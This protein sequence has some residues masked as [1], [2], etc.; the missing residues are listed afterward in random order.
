MQAGDSFFLDGVAERHLWVI[1]SDPTVNPERVLFVSMTS[2][3]VTKEDVCL[4]DAGDH[5][6]V[7][8]KTCIDY[9]HAREATLT[10]LVRL[11]DS[12]RLRPHEPV[13]AELLGRIRRGVSLSRDIKFRYV[14]LLLD[15]GVID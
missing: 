3:D 2:F 5:S 9:S 11:R 12:G 1:I 15:Q 7:K 6:F 4:L 8:H 14:E 13:S 10:A